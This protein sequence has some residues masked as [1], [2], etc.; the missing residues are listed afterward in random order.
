VLLVQTKTI[1]IKS[2]EKIFIVRGL[3]D[4]KKSDTCM[5]MDED[6]FAKKLYLVSIPL[7]TISQSP[8]APGDGVISLTESDVR[9]KGRLLATVTPDP[10][11]STLA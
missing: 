5:K 2:K 4:L 7:P 8:P 11:R 6:P 10:S 1:I 9:V 3:E